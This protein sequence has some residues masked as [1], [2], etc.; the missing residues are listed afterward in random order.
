MAC[1]E[2]GD[3]QTHAFRSAEDLVYAV[4]LA[5]AEVERGVLRR[6]RAESLS[7]RQ[8]EALDSAFAASAVPASIRYWFECTVCRDQFEL[9]GDTRDGSGTWTRQE[10]GAGDLAPIDPKGETP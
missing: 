2:C 7:E 4:Q 5:A 3:L 10:R 9:S 1:E 8:Q 6:V